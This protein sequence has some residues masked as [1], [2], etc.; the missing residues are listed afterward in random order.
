M[1]DDFRRV[2]LAVAL[3]MMVWIGVSWLFP[4]SGSYWG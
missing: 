3:S 4:F 2:L 1:S